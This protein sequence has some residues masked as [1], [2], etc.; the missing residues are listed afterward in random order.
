MA[1]SR[2]APPPVSARPL[3]RW[4]RALPWWLLVVALLGAT[5]EAWLWQNA[6][7]L[8]QR[9]A[10]GVPLPA[11]PAAPAQAASNGAA[12]AATAAS[13]ASAATGAPP[14][15]AWLHDGQPLAWRFG[16]A[17]ALDAAGDSEAALA[18]YRSLYDDPVLGLHARY[19][20]ANVLLRQGISTSEERNAGAALPLYELA[21]EGYRQVLRLSPHHG[22][23]RYNL[24]RAQR[25]LPEF[26]APELPTAAPEHAER[27]AT[28]MRATGQGL[29]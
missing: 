15:A 25:L 3:P 17:L 29:P 26:D 28:T 10:Q 19:N 13:V 22:A 2:F 4:R 20:A 23:A 1:L 7:S 27:S 5:R 24:E 12:T 18:R 21:K 11:K 9:L 8:N 6:R 14:P 16:Q